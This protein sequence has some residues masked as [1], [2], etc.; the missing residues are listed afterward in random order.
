MKSLEN[1][2]NIEVKRDWQIIAIKGKENV[3]SVEIKDEQGHFFEVNT[4]VVFPLVGKTPASMFSSKLQIIDD[5]KYIEIDNNQKTRISGIYAAGDCTNN[6][7]K[8]IVTATSGGA[9]AAME[10]YKYIKKLK[11]ES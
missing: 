4:K 2:P 10:V 11:K 9:I 6:S 7:L 8:Q 5:K 3:S 1:K